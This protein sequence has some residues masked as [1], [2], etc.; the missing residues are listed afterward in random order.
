MRLKT[1]IFVWVFLSTLL[2]LTLL[3]LAATTYSEH[4]YQNQVNRDMTSRL[5]SLVSEI[6]RSLYYERQMVLALAGSADMRQY[7]PVLKSASEGVV[8]PGLFPRGERLSAFLASFQGV[9]PSFATLRVLDLRGNTMIK[10]RFGRGRVGIYDGIE[11]SP[12]AESELT[13]DRFAKLLGALPGADLS[14]VALPE[15]R[16]DRDGLR[17]PP[18]LDAV[19]PLALEGRRVGYLMADFSGEPIDRILE[20][21]PRVH[22]GQLLVAELNPDN[23]DRDGMVLYGDAQKLRLSDNVAA[24]VNLRQLHGGALWRAVQRKPYG[25]LSSRDGSARTYYLEYL[26]YSN[27]LASWV[28]AARVDMNALLAPFNR[29]RLGI[30]L[31]AGVALAV[32]LLLARIGAR[33]VAAPVTEMARSL[34]RYA[35]GDHDV[36]VRVQGADEIRQLETSFNYMADTLARARDERDRA[37][38]MVQQSSKLASIGQMAAG[39]GHEINNPLGNILSLCKLIARSLPP[40]QDKLQRDVASLREEALRASGIVKGI[41][42]FAR[43]VPPEY[44]RF[45]VTPWVEET[46]ALVNQAAR[47]RRVRL[48]VE[49]AGD[50]RIEGDRNQLQQVLVNL[51]LNAVQA[52]PQ[53]GEV[54]VSTSYSGGRFLVQVHDQGP[55]IEPAVLERMYDPFFTTKAVGEGS[56]LG[57]SVSL[58]IVERHG[59][60]LQVANTGHGVTAT[61]SLPLSRQA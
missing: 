53:G 19:V 5:S 18:M 2:P 59:G 61:I 46:L 49:T 10:V 57:L 47:E 4:R 20:L 42:N 33:N 16:W 45:A 14:F 38:H 22:Q 40:G 60:E 9:V 15:I 43:Q 25:E 30:L 34:K 21:A 24:P 35:D 54:R 41:L 39:I 29:L 8:H 36:R 3:V 52:S 23:R 1:N 56:G 26:P 27:Q 28:V 31:V 6:D 48:T 50:Q 58:G 55:G 37:Q 12:F 17:G 7:L 51:L 11:S 44:S 13:D 32:S